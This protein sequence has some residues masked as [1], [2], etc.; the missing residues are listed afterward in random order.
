ML[1]R[2]LAGASLPDSHLASAGTNEAS[3][4]E[5]AAYEGEPWQ[6][7]E[8]IPSSPLGAALGFLLLLILSIQGQ[9]RRSCHRRLLAVEPPNVE[10]SRCCR[11]F[12]RSFGG[13]V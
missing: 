7:F 2:L 3:V 13:S 11:L 12:G 10:T 1:G 8:S 9:V 4:W 6:R 5:A